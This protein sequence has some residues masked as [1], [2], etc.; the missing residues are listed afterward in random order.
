MDT[1]PNTSQASDERPRRGRRLFLICGGGLLA[2]AA[3]GATACRSLPKAELEERL[4]A[5]EKNASAPA[6]LASRGAFRYL[7]AGEDEPGT[8]GRG[9]IV[10][11]H[12]TPACLFDWIDVIEHGAG[13]QPGLAADGPVYALDV[14]G[15]GV[16]RTSPASCASFWAH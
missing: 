5:L 4:L 3:L 10:L 11:V 16:T 15:H 12:G 2:F 1:A 6:L 14:V 7:A 8:G 13:D 9:P